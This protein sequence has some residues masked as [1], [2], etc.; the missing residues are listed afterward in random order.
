MLLTTVGC[1]SKG[2]SDYYDILK[3]RGYTFLAGFDFNNSYD[4]EGNCYDED[5]EM[6]DQVRLVEKPKKIARLS[7]VNKE[8]HYK[9][10]FAVDKKGEVSGLIYSSDDG[11]Y[12]IDLEKDSKNVTVV[13]N[14]NYCNTNFKGKADSD[15]K[16][17]GSEQIKIADKIKKEYENIFEECN[18][19]END[20]IETAKWFNEEKVPAIKKDITKK[21]DEQKPLTNDEIIE[22]FEDNDYKY[23]KSEDGSMTFMYVDDL[24]INNKTYTAY[25]QEGK[26]IIGIGFSYGLFTEPGFGKTGLMYFYYPNTKISGA[27]STDG[28]VMYSLTGKQSLGEVEADEEF[29]KNA[30][31]MEFTFEN[32]LNEIHL[33][34]EDLVRFFKTVK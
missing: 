9:L 31:L 17:C 34:K 14:G 23:V 28:K 11:N 18:F 13:E 16:K 12:K 25:V 20:L 30:G 32:S 5:G 29:I 26:G 19:E 2:P 4:D 15:Y 6:I 24:N 27:I 33:T 1:G 7:L 8:E 21:Y 10:I 3:E 22:I